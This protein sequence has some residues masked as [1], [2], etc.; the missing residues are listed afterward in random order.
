MPK[1]TR[2]AVESIRMLTLAR[3]STV[4]P[5]STAQT[6]LQNVLVTAPYAL[7]E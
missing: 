5:R 3:N 1:N 6:Q 2:G 7:R 4:K